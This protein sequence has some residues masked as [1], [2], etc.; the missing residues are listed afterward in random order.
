MAEA[1]ADRLAD[2]AAGDLD[3]WSGPIG[4]AALGPSPIR[5]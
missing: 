4:D 1:A 2:T 5:L 3:G